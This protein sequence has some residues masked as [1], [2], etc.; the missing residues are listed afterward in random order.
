[1]MIQPQIDFCCFRLV[2]INRPIALTHCY[3]LVSFLNLIT[4]KYE[5]TID[6]EL[7]HR[8]AHGQTLHVYSPGSG[9]F[10]RE[11]TSRLQ[12]YV[13]SKVRYQSNYAYLR[14]EHSCQI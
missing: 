1:M 6:Q 7:L 2:T 10:L 3:K 13:K 4:S 11:I 5:S 8:C 14:E 12:S 9:T